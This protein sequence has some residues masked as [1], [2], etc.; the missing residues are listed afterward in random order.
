MNKKD[1][2]TMQ[3]SHTTPS[4]IPGLCRRALGSSLAIIGAVAVLGLGGCSSVAVGDPDP[5]T[6]IP[7]ATAVP[8]MPGVSG[9]SGT[10]NHTMQD[11]AAVTD[12]SDGS[13]GGR[14]V[15]VAP[16]G[17]VEAQ[18][19]V[20]VGLSVDGATRA[21][22]T[23]T[24]TDITRTQ[25]CPSRIAEP[26]V[27]TPE[28]G[29]FLVVDLSAQMAADYA[30][31]DPDAPFLT[32]D[33]DAFHLTDREGNIQEDS[34]TMASYGC[35]STEERVTPFINPGENA[36]GKVVLETS[37]EHGYLVYN[38]WGVPGSGWRWAF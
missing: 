34:H 3:N 32:L 37:L 10:G 26:A 4:S 7:V 28:N 11:R 17:D 6:P 25:E 2:E 16:S 12:G 38:P 33:R 8:S 13:E 27:F 31:Y 19:G 23:L 18:L 1:D 5:V 24:V 20:P 9:A 35:Y 21:A 29:T 22:F 36:G 15:T 30:A 14:P